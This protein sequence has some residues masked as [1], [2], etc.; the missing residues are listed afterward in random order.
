MLWDWFNVVIFEFYRDGKAMRGVENIN[1]TWLEEAGDGGGACGKMDDG[2]DP[3]IGRGRSEL[4]V[5]RLA[6][7]FCEVMRHQNPPRMGHLGS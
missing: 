2:H 7:R 3:S 6:L 1:S 4:R 5:S